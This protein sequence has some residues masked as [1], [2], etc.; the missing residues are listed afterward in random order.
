MNLTKASAV[1]G[2]RKNKAGMVTAFNINR[3]TWGRGQRG[4]YLFNFIKQNDEGD[5]I[6]QVNMC[7]LGVYARACGISV[8][9]LN[10]KSMYSNLNG[11]LPVG[12]KLFLVD[13]YEDTNLAGDLASFNDSRD[14]SDDYKE[15]N[16]IKKF[17][18]LG[19]KVRFVGRG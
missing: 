5:Q 10:K 11:R 17:A 13:S 6:D 14:S 3:K 7:C 2:I 18:E 12:I 4:G 8:K 1:T 15:A 19:I 16:I 9:R